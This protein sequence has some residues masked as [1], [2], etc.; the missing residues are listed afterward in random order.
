[1]VFYNTLFKFVGGQLL[2][3]SSSFVNPLPPPK[4]CWH[5]PQVFYLPHSYFRYNKLGLDHRHGREA[6]LT[7]T[8]VQDSPSFLSA[9][10]YPLTEIPVINVGLGTSHS[11]VLSGTN[12]LL[13]LQKQWRDQNKVQFPFCKCIELKGKV[14][15]IVFS[16]LHQCIGWK[17][18]LR[19]WTLKMKSS[20]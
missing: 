18:C 11:A 16:C 4:F 8:Q 3:H 13:P 7:P 15:T 5:L 2:F 14:I 20:K 19:N 12:Y 1:M 17:H 9:S 6:E 10:T